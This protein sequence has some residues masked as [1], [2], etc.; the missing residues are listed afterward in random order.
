MSERLSSG[1]SSQRPEQYGRGQL[2]ALLRW[3][4]CAFRV[5]ILRAALRRSRD[6]E[7]DDTRAS[8]RQPVLKCVREDGGQRL[9]PRLGSSAVPNLGRRVHKGVDVVHQPRDVHPDV[10]VL[11][12]VPKNS[13]LRADYMRHRHG[14]TPTEA[15]EAVRDIDA[16]WFDP[17]PKSNSGESVRVIGYSHTGQAILTVILVAKEGGFGWYGGN[18]CTSNSTERRMYEEA[19]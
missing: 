12:H 2:E 13:A 17:D 9:L 6:M 7:R 16:G 14:V 3:P 1:T 19:D 11:C 18:G 15:D 5:V 8:D 10:C 4:E